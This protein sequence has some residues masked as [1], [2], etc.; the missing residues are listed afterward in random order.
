MSVDILI[1]HPDASK[2]RQLRDMVR[3]RGFKSCETDSAVEGV[4]LAR[5][6]GPRGVI[7]DMSPNGMDGFVALKLIRAQLGE[8]AQVISI[9]VEDPGLQSLAIE[10]GANDASNGETQHVG[11]FLTS[12]SPARAA[13]N[14]I[15]S[16][17]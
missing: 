6:A 8:T 1:I 16:L 4:L 3:Q 14:V 9:G 12:L 10:L 15:S 11:R 2:R 13:A 5:E 7:M 17:P